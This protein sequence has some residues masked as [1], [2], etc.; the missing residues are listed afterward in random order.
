MLFDK[1]IEHRLAVYSLF[2]LDEALNYLTNAKNS[3]HG[4]SQVLFEAK[5]I[6]TRY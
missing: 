5:L 1:S 2:S 3:V 4:C 6:I